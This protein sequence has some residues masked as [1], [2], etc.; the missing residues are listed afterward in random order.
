MIRKKITLE[1]RTGERSYL[2]LCDDESPLGEVY[3]ALI[4]LKAYVIKRILEEEKEN[5]PK[6][7]FDGMKK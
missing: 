7:D 4:I 1:H 3:D 6:S 2:F 5:S